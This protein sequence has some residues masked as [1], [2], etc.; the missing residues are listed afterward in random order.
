[1]TLATSAATQNSFAIKDGGELFIESHPFQDGTTLT[2]SAQNVRTERTGLHGRIALL[3]GEV[4]LAY[5][6]F[7][8][9]RSEDRNR[10]GKTAYAKLSPELQ[11]FMPVNTI[12]H[13]LDVFCLRVERAHESERFQIVEHDPDADLP[14]LTFPLAPYILDGAGTIAFAP[15]GSLKSYVTQAMAVSLA[16]GHS[17]LW[18]V[19]KRPAL[20]INLERSANSMALRERGI[21]RAM[22]LAGRSGV[23]YLHKRGV[24][25][26]ALSRKVRDWNREHEG[27]VTFLDSVSRAQLGDTL[28]SDEAG[29]AF[30]D[31]M[32][33]CAPTWW[34]IGHTS[35]DNADHVFGS[36][37]FD[38]GQ[39]IGIK[40]S[41]ERPDPKDGETTERRGVALEVTKANDMRFPPPSYLAFTF[42]A[43]GLTGISK[44]RSTD[45][46]GLAAGVKQSRT[47]KLF[48]YVQRLGSVTGSDAALELGLDRGWV[49]SVFTKSGSYFL[50]K[51]EG[52]KLFYAVK[53]QV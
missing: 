49:S 44:A 28:N 38:A 19:E 36:Q 42:G 31:I 15:P 51:R 22:G 50:A 43:Y 25:L 20:Y 6:T 2:L 40:M 41:S 1:M 5:D 17:G 11:A 23:S 26:R 45:F 13:V 37:M 47:T 46:P 4:A 3:R 48:E 52:H 27:G 18:Q 53:E 33:W 29:N 10:L 12:Q 34:G 30:I 16:T 39:D 9:T 35:R 7:N 8:I 24:S 21:L 14:P 32:N